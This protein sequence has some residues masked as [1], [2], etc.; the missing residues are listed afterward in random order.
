MELNI[1][2]IY[3]YH[4]R[5]CTNKNIKK[6]VMFRGKRPCIVFPGWV[7]ECEYKIEYNNSEEEEECVCQAA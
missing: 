2:C 3:N 7:E 1:N 5:V 6:S 4:G